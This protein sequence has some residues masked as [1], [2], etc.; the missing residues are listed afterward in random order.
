MKRLILLLVL[1]LVP[2]SADARVSA[3]YA[4]NN[5][6]QQIIRFVNHSP[7]WYSCFYQDQVNYYT[8]TL[9]PGQASYWYPIYGQYRW[10]C[11]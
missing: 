9:G 4:N 8:F 2:M 5:R 7:R 3:Q 6:G 10:Q 1:L 11:R